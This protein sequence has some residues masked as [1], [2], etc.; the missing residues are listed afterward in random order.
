MHSLYTAQTAFAALRRNVSRTLLTILGIVIGVAAIMMVMSLGESA[1]ILIVGELGG[2]GAETIVVRPGKEPEG[3][4]DIAEA[5]FSDSLK[6]RELD[7]ILSG[8]IPGIAEASP[9]VFTPGSV[10]FGRET[11]SAT[12]LGFSAEFMELALG[13]VLAEGRLFDNFEIRS[14]SRVAVIGARVKD[15]LFGDSDALGEFINIKGQKFRVVGIYRPRGQVVFFDV[16]ELVL[17]PYT[18]AQEY[19]AGIDYYNQIIV[20][21]TSP[22]IVPEVQR[23]LIES[24]RVLHGITDPK[25]DDFY[26]QTQQGLVDQVSSII[27]V[28]T[29]FLSFVVAIA[30]V[31][32]GIGVM[33]IMLVSVTERTK[34]IGLRKA[35]GATRQDILRQFLLESVILTG[36]GGILGIIIGSTLAFASA[37]LVS[38]FGGI[39]LT[40][41]FPWLGAFLGVFVSAVVGIIFGLYPAK[42]AAEKSPTEALRYE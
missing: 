11:F 38:R 20:Q 10:S 13:L 40:F 5:L 4:A 22:E 30:L 15:E 37:T 42:K 31:V 24:L 36:M 27:A 8:K 3:P 35:L 1:Q 34:E 2:L 33:N 26:I 39:V 19:L 7:Y 6:Q 17:V 14:Q 16:D 9:E 12:I 18:T 29:M 25:E 21:A 41:S 28:F 23:E 32:G